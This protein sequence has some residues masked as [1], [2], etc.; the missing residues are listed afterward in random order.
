MNREL[1]QRAHD[2]LSTA[3]KQNCHD[4]MLTG[5]ELRGIFHTI[6]ELRAAL[7]APVAPAIPPDANQALHDAYVAGQKD[8]ARYVQ[9]RM[10]REVEV[11]RIERDDARRM[12][13]ASMKHILDGAALQLPSITLQADIPPN[14]QRDAERLDWILLNVSGNEFR[15]I[16]VQYSGNARRADVDAAMAAPKP[17]Q[18]TGHRIKTAGFCKV[19][20]HDRIYDEGCARADCPDAPKPPSP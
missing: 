8:G 2:A 12:R 4:M 17:P 19:C 11:L 9:E 13:D 3:H 14:V 5:D 18:P 10:Q 6:A 15:R 20:R 1:M 16:G 7:A